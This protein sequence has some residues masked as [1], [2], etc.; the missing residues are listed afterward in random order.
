[1]DRRT[2]LKG[3]AVAGC[4]VAGVP[5]RGRAQEGH[6]ADPGSYAMLYDAT[7][8]IGCQACVVACRDANDLEPPPGPHARV[9]GLQGDTAN[10]IK[11]FRSPDGGRSS[12]V[13][14]QCM[15]CADPAC[16][17]ACMLGS[18]QKR[19]G[20][21]VTWKPGLC[22]GCRYCQI[23]CPFNIPKFEWDSATPR[24]IKCQLCVTKAGTDDE[25]GPVAEGGIPACCDVCPVDAVVFGSRGE[26]LT[27]A[28]ERIEA[29]PDRYLD[30]VYGEHEAGGTQVM[31]LTGPDV[32]FR[33]IGLPDYSDEAVPEPARNVQHTVYKGFIAPV[34]L[35]GLMAAAVFRS[36]RE[37]EAEEGAGGDRAA[38]TEGG[39]R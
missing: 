11:M 22:V 8:C 1:M 27:E 30:H 15:H 13:K 6:E 33:E 32:S 17:T 7:R 34:A 20:G 38:K 19:E 18:L 29:E 16:V 3:M 14:N 25:P 31:Y 5:A 28:H 26:L 37:L 12:Y 23:A 24:I 10:V 35:Y 2:A 21:A 4:A 39:D 36:R 9:P